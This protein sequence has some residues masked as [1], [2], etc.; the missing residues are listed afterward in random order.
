MLAPDRLRAAR[1]RGFTLIEL[2][3]VIALLAV[4]V[5]MVTLSLRDGQSSQLDDEA[6]RLTA[7]LEGARARSRAMGVAVRW[8]PGTPDNP[9]FRF[10][11]LPPTVV[12]PNQWLH[13]GT[14]AQVLDAPALVLGPEPVIGPQRL[15]L[16]LGEREL[17]LA[18]D[19]LE[20]FVPVAAPPD[21]R[22][23]TTAPGAG[24]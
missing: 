18:T 17:L 2:L 9:G 11:G 24:S 14:Q 12:L 15:R 5:G 13:A 22:S 23:E 7:L 20:P 3:L 4:V 19:G 1:V 10:I 21:T 16:R 6:A 8:Q